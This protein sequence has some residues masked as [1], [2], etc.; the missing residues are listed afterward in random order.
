MTRP[1]LSTP[2]AGLSVWN[3]S[4]PGTSAFSAFGQSENDQRGQTLGRRR[5]VVDRAGVEFHAQWIGDAGVITLQILARHRA[6]DFF[7]IGRDLAPNVAA[8]EIIE[9]GAR[10]MIER[11][12]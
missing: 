12:R 3:G 4:R 6:A 11:K 9:A 8:I 7:Q 1:S 5:R 10:D 2:S